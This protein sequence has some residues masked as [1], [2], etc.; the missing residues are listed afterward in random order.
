MDYIEPFQKKTLEEGE[1][2]LAL[3][4]EIYNY[5]AGAERV[6]PSLP[7]GE[8]SEHLVVAR[9]L[10]DRDVQG[11]SSRILWMKKC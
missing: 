11:T 9:A 3:F 1:N 4:G 8:L 10:N 5:R 2:G 7:H 6:N